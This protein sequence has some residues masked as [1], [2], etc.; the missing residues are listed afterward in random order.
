[1][2]EFLKPPGTPYAELFIENR[3][4]ELVV[5]M[6]ADVALDYNKWAN[7][8]SWGG[9]EGYPRDQSF[10]YAIN[11]IKNDYLGVRRIHL[12]VKH[13]VDRLASYNI[14]GSYSAEIPNVQPTDPVIRF[15]VYEFN[16]LSGNQDEEYIELL[17]SNSYAVDIS[18]WRLVGGVEYKFLPGTVIVSGGNLYVSPDVSSFRSRAISP[19]GGEGR[20]VQGNY[21]GHLSNWGETVNLLDGYGRLVS[22]LMYSGNPSEQQ[23]YLRVTEIMYN[24]GEGGI[25]DNDEYEF[26]EL[27]NI[28]SVPLVLNGIKFT[29]GISY[30]FGDNRNVVLAAGAHMVI[31]KNRTAFA[32]R[33]DTRNVNLAPSAYTGNLSNGGETIKIEDRTNSTI[34]EFSY[35]DNWFDETDGL[36]FSLTIKDATNPDRGSWDSIDAWRPSAEAGGSPGFDDT[37]GLPNTL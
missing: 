9:Q 29:G 2:D 15:G 21:K 7:P 28:G 26:I 35:K 10:E 1:M 20:F 34:I 33:Y 5:V 8:W 23:R 36:G 14:P 32:L 25:F 24:P 19:T 30:A 6:S 13:N 27:K 4:D 3:I 37:E 18:D 22:S 17:N 16:P 12:F 11:V 31:V